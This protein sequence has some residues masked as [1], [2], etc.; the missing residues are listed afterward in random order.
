M[1]TVLMCMGLVLSFMMAAPPAYCAQDSASFSRDSTRHKMWAELGLSQDQQA[2]LKGMRKDMKEFR[3]QNFEKM[4]VLLDKTKEELLKTSPNKS[5][6]FGY[7]KEMG[8]LH[9]AMA[10]HMADHML[11]LK[12]V[13]TKEQFAKLLSNEFHP[14]MGGGRPGHGPHGG[15]GGPPDFN[16]D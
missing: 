1:R 16:N 2:K 15:P 13:L 14:P 4:K 8:E 5:T 11:F 10:E 12:S 9:K 3:E 7:A 6:L